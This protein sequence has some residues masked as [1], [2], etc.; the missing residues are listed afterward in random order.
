MVLVSATTATRRRC[1]PTTRAAARVSRRLPV[2]RG[3]G[4]WLKARGIAIES[5]ASFG[6]FGAILGCV[7]AGMGVAILPKRITTE[8]VA[9]KELRAHSFDD[10]DSVTTYLVTSE[11]PELP[12]TDTLRAVLGRQAGALLG[13]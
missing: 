2:S 3:R 12:E 4:H 5:V 6:T 11:A 7:A 13:R 10:L 9:R 8:H 1:W